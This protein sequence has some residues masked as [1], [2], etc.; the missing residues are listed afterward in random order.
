MAMVHWHTA[1]LQ[2]QLAA[3]ELLLPGSC[4]QY[5]LSNQVAHH[6]LAIPASV[7]TKHNKQKDQTQQTKGL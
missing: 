1:R 7:V 4:C 2:G 3:L 5:L 6:A